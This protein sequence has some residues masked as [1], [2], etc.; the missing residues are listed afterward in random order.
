[1]WL[2]LPQVAAT[3]RMGTWSNG[4]LRTHCRSMSTA[5]SALW[6]STVS[7]TYRSSARTSQWVTG[8]VDTLFTQLRSSL[9][10]HWCVLCS[11][12]MVSTLKVRTLPTMVASVRLSGHTT[13]SGA[14]FLANS[15][16]QVS[17]NI[18]P[19]SSSS[20]ASHMWVHDIHAYTYTHMKEMI[21]LT[22][23][24][25][26]QSQGTPAA[27]GCR[28]EM[29]MECW[30]NGHRDWKQKCTLKKRPNGIHRLYWDLTRD[31]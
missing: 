28:W 21:T 3:T 6:S 18:L 26:T 31:N 23:V 30:W 20:L 24:C 5:Y 16:Y 13:N 10:R 2:V 15:C 9:D 7:T 25:G 8:G 19:N 17:H 22:S 4:G 27:S 11:R 14:E 12:W 1:M 29:G